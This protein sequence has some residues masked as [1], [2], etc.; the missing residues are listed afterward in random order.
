MSENEVRV[1]GPPGTG[2]TTWV[3]ASV[4]ATAKNRRTSRL[5]VGSFTRAAATEIAGRGLPVN[6]D[7][8]GT[9]HALAYRAID[10]PSVTGNDEVAGWNRAKPHLAMSSGFV[11]TDESPD[12]VRGGTEADRI[13]AQMEML[14][15]QE[16]PLTT[17]PVAVRRFHAEWTDW[18]RGEGLIDF[19]DMIELA[20][21]NT[22]EAP[23][24]PVVGFFDEVQD[25]T[26]LE[27][28]LVRHWGKRMERLV[29]AGDDDQSIYGFK[30]ATPDAFLDP[31]IPDSQKRVLHQSYRVPRA[32][33]ASAKAWV[34]RLSRREPK[35][36]EPRDHDGEVQLVELRGE[37]PE[38]LVSDVAK[39]LDERIVDEVTGESRPATVMILASCS[40]MLD[41]VKHQL[42]AEG[43]PFH[44]PY[45]RRRGDWNP[46]SAGRGTPAAERLM[47]YLIS[48]ERCFGHEAHLWTGD[49][50]RSWTAS[51]RKKGLFRRGANGSIG[52]LPS[53]ELTYEEVAALFECPSDVLAKILEPD[54]EWFAANLLAG[55][56]GGMAYPL[57]IARRDPRL[58]V[59]EPQVII[60]TIHS[61]KGG[62]ADTVYLLPDLSNGAMR[63]WTGAPQARDGVI[64]QMYVG[65]TRARER[66]LLCQPSSPL[67]VEPHLMAQ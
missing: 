1:F 35:D 36:Y 58:L 49:D 42:R 39:R 31:P 6:N 22:E 61:V 65:M 17:W 30:G 41:R 24:K 20:L 23:G 66:L 25:F 28:S 29:L 63:E 14:R 13:F 59:S 7:Q 64:R 21:H 4:R 26:P 55:A 46:L 9:L 38:P 56:R 54:L 10:R 33:H 12:V 8:V 15:A 53:R 44:N 27:L 2:K 18:K 16:V 62:Q 52:S 60:G 67:A 34:E 11:G 43:V 45:R 5:I 32:V 57:S 50:V 48:D 3:A 37:L 40:Y 19:T 51:V 47:A